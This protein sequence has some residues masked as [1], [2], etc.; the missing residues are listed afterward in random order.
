MGSRRKAR[1]LALQALYSWDYTS[2][3]STELGRFE[4]LDEER[5]AKYEDDTLVFARLI[6]QGTL[7][8]IDEIDRKIKEQLEHWDFNR[9]ARVDLSILRFSIYGLLYQNEIPTT[10]TIDEA[11]DLAKQYG[12]GESYRFVNGVLDGV[13]KHSAEK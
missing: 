12:S 11:I 8:N 10:V 4:W 7:E 13:R 3:S 6:I 2:Q 1:I 9:L 5:R